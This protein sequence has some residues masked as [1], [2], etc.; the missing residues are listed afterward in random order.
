MTSSANMACQRIC[1][2]TKPPWN[3]TTKFRTVLQHRSKTAPPTKASH[4]DDLSEEDKERYEDDFGED[5]GEGGV[6]VPDHIDADALNRFVM[7][8][9]TV[10]AVLQDLMEHGIKTMGGEQM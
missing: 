8:A 7:N 2:N 3:E 1:T 10:D 5:D 4:D 6:E 9:G